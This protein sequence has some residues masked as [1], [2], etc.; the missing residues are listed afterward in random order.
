MESENYFSV[1]CRLPV[2]IAALA[3]LDPNCDDASFEAHIPDV[4]RLAG[5]VA[6]LDAAGLRSLR[7]VGDSAR[8]LAEHL[9][10]LSR[11]IN[12]VMGY[13]LLREDDAANRCHSRRLS[14][15]A[16]WLDEP[17]PLPE[18][19]AVSIKL[20]VPEEQLAIYGWGQVAA[21]TAEGSQIRFTRLREQ[22]RE[23]LIRVT[24]HQQTRL[25][26][27]RAARKENP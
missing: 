26:K 21:T 11:K 22:D 24:L 27:A 6:T 4:F 25:L 7:A 5:E 12:A 13:V 20:F 18:G 16:L 23:L 17:L 1:P 14:A 19:S 2:N 3:G 8:E 10:L 15:E 9:N